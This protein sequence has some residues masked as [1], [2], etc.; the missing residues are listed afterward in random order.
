MPPFFDQSMY[1]T[2]EEVY[3]DGF[4]EG[5]RVGLADVGLAD[6]GLVEEGCDRCNIWNVINFNVRGGEKIAGCCHS[7]YLSLTTPIGGGRHIRWG[8]GPCATSG[9]AV[10]HVCGHI[11]TLW[12]R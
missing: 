5:D 12:A 6:V 11:I 8:R 1:Q 3:A 2:V 4:F 10:S 7:R 9:G